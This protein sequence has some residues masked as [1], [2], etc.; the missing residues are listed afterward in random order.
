VWRRG[1]G[2]P[3]GEQSQQQYRDEHPCLHSPACSASHCTI[4]FL[5]LPP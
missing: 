4:R 2:W 3:G 5:T 1:S